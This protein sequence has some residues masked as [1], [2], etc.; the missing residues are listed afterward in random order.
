MI[1]SAKRNIQRVTVTDVNQKFVEILYGSSG[2]S[3]LAK[4]WFPG[5]KEGQVWELTFYGFQVVR[6]ERIL[7]TQEQQ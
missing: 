6:C 5:V 4:K 7:N 3:I 2:T 1:K